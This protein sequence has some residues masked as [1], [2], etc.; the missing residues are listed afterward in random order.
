[1]KFKVLAAGKS[2]PIDKPNRAYLVTDNWDDWFEFSTMYT[3]IY[4]D[5]DQKKW[6]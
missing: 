3:L 5:G 4:V 2:C 1:M 6:K